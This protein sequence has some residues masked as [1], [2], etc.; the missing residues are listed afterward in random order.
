ME[1]AT[2]MKPI[3]LLR[4]VRRLRHIKRVV[5]RGFELYQ[6]E[7]LMLDVYYTLTLLAEGEEGGGLVL[8]TSEVVRQTLNPTWEAVRFEEEGLWEDPR[9]VL[10]TRCVLRVHWRNSGEGRGEELLQSVSGTLPLDPRKLS[11][12]L[13]AAASANSSS[14]SSSS[15]LVNGVVPAS[16]PASHRRSVYVMSSSAPAPSTSTSASAVQAGDV[17]LMESVLDVR[18]LEYIAPK[19]FSALTNMPPNTV[20]FVLADGVYG[21][22]ATKA[23]LAKDQRVKIE[24]ESKNDYLCRVI[25][26]NSTLEYINRVHAEKEKLRA[27]KQEIQTIE[28]LLQEKLM[29]RHAT[30]IRK[31]EQASNK[32]RLEQLLASIA[33]EEKALKEQRA[34]IKTARTNMLKRAE[35]MIKPT[36]ELQALHSA[37]TSSS[38]SPSSPTNTSATAT[39]SSAA[40]AAAAAAD[41]APSDTPSDVKSTVLV[42]E[43]TSDEQLREQY[44]ATCRII[45]LRRKKMIFSLLQIY[46]I[47]SPNPQRERKFFSISGLPLP[48]SNLVNYEDE[49]VSGALGLCAHLISLLAKYLS[50]K[51]RYRVVY[52][53]SRSFVCDDYSTA[54]NNLPQTLKFPLYYKGVDEKRFDFACKLLAKNVEQ[55]LCARVPGSEAKIQQHSSSLL[56]MLVFYLNNEVRTSMDRKG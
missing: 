56:K 12:P 53:G 49:S 2:G 23:F 31:N 32:A 21:F 38:S 54:D 17:L 22:P 30:L 27:R 7:A 48:G 1:S 40:A 37:A 52:V 50:I 41:V 47:D 55:L 4:N 39:L 42:T 3:S 9:F 44:A 11:V 6:P 46:R 28:T 43:E 16:T 24:A 36:E 29:A 20:L 33:N 25:T 10:G 14:S 15:S 19:D 35:S 51:L 45:D 18:E 13:A 26:V 34:H 5:G 8:Y